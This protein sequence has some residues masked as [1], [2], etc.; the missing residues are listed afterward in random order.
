MG[1]TYC[2][3]TACLATSGLSWKAVRACACWRSA[4]RCPRCVCYR[5]ARWGRFWARVWV[6]WWACAFGLWDGGSNAVRV[7]CGVGVSWV[8]A[9][10]C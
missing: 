1:L 4:V 8:V 9:C 3:S 6:G 5:W 10:G 2:T 7:L